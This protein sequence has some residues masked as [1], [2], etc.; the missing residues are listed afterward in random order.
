MTKSGAVAVL[1]SM[2]RQLPDLR[3]VKFYTRTAADTYTEAPTLFHARRE[4]RTIALID[5]LT[6]TLA[7]WHLYAI[8]G[9]T[10]EPK[11]MGKIVDTYTVAS[12]ETWYIPGDGRVLRSYFD[13]K[14]DIPNCV[15][16]VS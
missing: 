5:G 15:L 16:A 13:L 9:Q 10:T 8:D 14:F 6:V 2:V 4:P 12:G 11:P 3:V 7:T 1:T